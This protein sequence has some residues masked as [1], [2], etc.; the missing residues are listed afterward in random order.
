MPDSAITAWGEAGYVRRPSSPHLPLPVQTERRTRPILHDDP[1]PVRDWDP[2]SIPNP[3]IRSTT[4]NWRCQGSGQ[5]AH[6]A[7]SKTGLAEQGSAAARIPLRR[8]D[9]PVRRSLSGSIAG[10]PPRDAVVAEDPP[11]S[12]AMVSSGQGS[13]VR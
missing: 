8:H 11:M 4:A 10:D 5:E 13:R 6:P 2:F 12:R 7:A 3:A 9:A 1:H